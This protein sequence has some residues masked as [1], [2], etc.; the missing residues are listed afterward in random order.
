M[1]GSKRVVIFAAAL[2]FVSTA[3]ASSVNTVFTLDASQSQVTLNAVIG[4][5]VPVVEQAPGSLTS[6]L[7]GT[8]AVQIELAGSVPTTLAITSTSSVYAMEHPG[9]FQPDGGPADFAGIYDLGAI[10]PG[11]VGTSSIHDFV[12]DISGGPQA[13]D[14]VGEFEVAGLFL[15]TTATMNWDAPGITSGS[16][17]G[18]LDDYIT[19][20]STGHLSLVGDLLMLTL[21]YSIDLPD[22][23]AALGGIEVNYRLT[24]LIVA[25][26]I[27]PEPQTTMWMAA[28]GAGLAMGALRVRRTAGGRRA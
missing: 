13:V 12:T 3:H 24:G 17:N 16:Y 7:D 28:V 5:V 8:L 6:H 22:A 21:P 20:S 4:G 11:V 19:E 15:R 26:A 23:P 1:H 2:S 9:D 14:G 10:F 25:T 27:V 18:Y